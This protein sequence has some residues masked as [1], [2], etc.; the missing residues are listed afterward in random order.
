MPECA[1]SGTDQCACADEI[2]RL[3]KVVRALV[4][5]AERNADVPAS[6]FGL[7]QTRINLEG[8]VKR[9]TAE[10]AKA[11]AE[12]ET[13]TRALRAS[14]TK[15]SEAV[16]TG[17]LAALSEVL[18]LA[19]PIGMARA[20]RIRTLTG[21]LGRVYKLKRLKH[22]QDVAFLSQIG[23]LI[24]P[25]GVTA[26]LHSGDLLTENERKMVRRMPEVADRLLAKIP[27]TEAE[28]RIVRLQDVH[29]REDDIPIQALI[30]RV[31]IG[32][33]RL[34][35][36]GE[37]PERCIRI[38][39]SRD[40]MYSAVVLECLEAY[41]ADHVAE[42]ASHVNVAVLVPGMTVQEDVVGT[43]GRLLLRS[44]AVLTGVLIEKIANLANLDLIRKVVLVSTPGGRPTR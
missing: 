11:L 17:C 31:A 23:T 25:S 15:F 26:K 4:D 8:E 38:M 6:E 37:T 27:G 29:I 28:R 5:R 44:G 21:E 20:L 7:F 24:L 12:N 39:H 32:F 36:S 1:S 2:A 3:N 9:R 16:L 40:P 41:L 34:D 30:L 13:I 35:A 19:D 43:D 14:E 18:A 22:L 33:D 10:L 42:Q